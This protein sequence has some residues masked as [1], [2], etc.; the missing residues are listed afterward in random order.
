MS[1]YLQLLRDFVRLVNII[2]ALMVETDCVMSKEEIIL[3]KNF[4]KGNT[5][6]Y[7]DIFLLSRASINTYQIIKPF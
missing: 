4:I 2:F 7:L 3:H 5:D 1:S 6:Q